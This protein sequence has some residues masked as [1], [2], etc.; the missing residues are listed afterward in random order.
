[1][2]HLI[3]ILPELWCTWDLIP[4]HGY[5]IRLPRLEALVAL[6]L[7]GLAT[8]WVAEEAEKI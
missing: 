2:I 1:M 5:R 3:L 8:T 6:N 4:S 7:S